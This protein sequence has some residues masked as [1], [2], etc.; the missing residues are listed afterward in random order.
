MNTNETSD[1]ASAENS[2]ER[3]PVKLKLL[4]D[5]NLENMSISELQDLHS[6]LLSIQTTQMTSG[7]Y[8]LL[9][10]TDTVRMEE[11]ENIIKDKERKY[12]VH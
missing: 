4:G 11:I 3:G 9:D 10:K 2:T 8:D 1:R 5:T 7:D 6:Q 12:T